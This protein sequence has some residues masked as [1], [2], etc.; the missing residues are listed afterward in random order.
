[1]TVFSSTNKGESYIGIVVLIGLEKGSNTHKN[2]KNW[3]EHQQQFPII[4]STDDY[5]TP[6]PSHS[7]TTHHVRI[8]GG[9]LTPDSVHSGT[10]LAALS[11]SSPASMEV[12]EKEAQN[13]P[14]AES[15]SFVHENNSNIT[16]AKNEVMQGH[17]QAKYN[18]QSQITY[19]TF[20]VPQHDDLKRSS[21][22]TSRI[23][24]RS[25]ECYSSSILNNV[26]HTNSS[27]SPKV[28]KLCFSEETDNSSIFAQQNTSSTTFA[29]SNCNN[30][31]MKGKKCSCNRSL[32][33]D[34]FFIYM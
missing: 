33:Y 24:A 28:A 22:I 30:L 15:G 9:C 26:F 23:D 14:A 31:K 5:S 13:F 19:P 20:N 17:F 21:Y 6:Q 16:T 34:T 2:E 8:P 7:P 11:S 29:R 10:D 12:M 25:T 27:S 3:G 4:S 18:T 1:M 32:F